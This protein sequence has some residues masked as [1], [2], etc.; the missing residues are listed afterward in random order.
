MVID[1]LIFY[2]FRVNFV[3]LFYKE[4]IHLYFPSRNSYGIME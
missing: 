4:I 2:L 3:H 1:L